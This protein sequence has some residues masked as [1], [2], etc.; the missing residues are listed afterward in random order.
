VQLSA[1]ADLASATWDV[2]VDGRWLGDGPGDRP[3][4]EFDALDPVRL[5]SARLIAVWLD[6]GETY[7]LSAL[8]P[9]GAKGHDKD[10]ITVALPEPHAT[11]QVFDPRLSTE[12]SS[13]GTPQRFG[14]E[15][16]LGE[17]AEGEQ[18]PV[19]LAGEAGPGQPALTQGTLSVY[20]MS[21]HTGDIQGLGLYLLVRP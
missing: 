4:V 12:Y 7:T 15:L 3:V 10:A 9:A 5:G 14:I 13:A 18:R 1:V 17:D 16:W 20:A 8:R 19:R 6:N 21:A 2:A 11:L